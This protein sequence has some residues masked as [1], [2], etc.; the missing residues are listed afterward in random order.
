[1]KPHA[2]AFFALTLASVPAVAVSQVT[3]SYQYDANGRLIGVT[4]TGPGG[5]NTAT[6]AYDDADNR[7]SRSQTGTTAYAALPRLP[8]GDDLR[9]R[10]ALVSPNGRFSLAVRDSGALEL[11]ADQAVVWSS[12]A[13]GPARPIF[14]IDAG[15]NA[16]FLGTALRDGPHS[17]AYLAL[18]DDG[19][20]ALF[21][22]LGATVLLRPARAL[23]VEASQ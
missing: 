11:W 10:Q 2:S 8:A 16:R 3:Q 7:T 19:D 20:L 5:T 23:N 14:A 17:G 6:Y 4:T 9:H 13:D 12:R 21:D 22:R 1:M 15:G 18:L